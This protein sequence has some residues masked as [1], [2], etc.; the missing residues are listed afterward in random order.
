MQAWIP[1]HRR[2]ARGPEPGGRSL[3]AALSLAEQP[4]GGARRVFVVQTPRSPGP[5][6][7][8]VALS[9]QEVSTAW[10]LPW[11]HPGSSGSGRCTWSCV[12]PPPCARPLTP[13][14][15][16][17]VQTHTTRHG[18]MSLISIQRRTMIERLLDSLYCCYVCEMV[19]R[20]SHTSRH[21]DAWCALTHSLSC[22][23]RHGPPR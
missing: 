23:L 4:E 11:V 21:L 8:P 14:H 15:C 5:V 18:V 12:Q 6:P 9:L 2:A 1:G 22:S 19:S 7:S 3:D 17:N 16:E 10:P 13:F 20:K